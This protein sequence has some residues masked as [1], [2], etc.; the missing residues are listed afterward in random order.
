MR[1]LPGP[2]RAA[3]QSCSANWQIHLHPGRLAMPSCGFRHNGGHLSG[4]WAHL[5]V[6]RCLSVQRN[7]KS[8]I[9]VYVSWTW[10]VFLCR[11]DR[12]RSVPSHQLAEGLEVDAWV[13][14]ATLMAVALAICRHIQPVRSERPKP[15]ISPRSA[16][17]QSIHS[18]AWHNRH[19]RNFVAWFIY[20]TAHIKLS[21]YIHTGI[22][23]ISR[24]HLCGLCSLH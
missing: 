12:T 6:I 1:Q 20:L 10:E 13:L 11:A 21:P 7:T 8:I 22:L 15:V 16:G 19:G 18:M 23:R 4:R 17:L 5:E 3:V 14:R 24:T 2:A 9:K